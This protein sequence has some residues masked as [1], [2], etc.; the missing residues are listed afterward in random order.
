MLIMQHRRLLLL[1]FMSTK[2]EGEKYIPLNN[3]VN[4]NVW[5]NNDDDVRVQAEYERKQT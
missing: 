4:M 1:I 2:R 3:Y 5:N